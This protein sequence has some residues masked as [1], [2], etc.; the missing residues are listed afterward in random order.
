MKH[1]LVSGVVLG[2]VHAAIVLSLGIQ[3][4]I[5]RERLPR[6]WAQAAA[7]APSSRVHGRYLTLN[8]VPL[9]DAGLAPRVDII[10]KRTIVRPTPIALEARNGRL[11]AHRAVASRVD[12]VRADASE[13]AGAMIAERVDCFLPPNAAD[14]MP[15]LRAG[16]LWVEV[17]VPRQGPPRPLRLGA[18]R[19]GRIEPLSAAR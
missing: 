18:M 13:D 7:A 16:E 12:L 8:L 6:A 5:G 2:V 15:L 17:S 19:N 1:P 11:L 4:A 14:P 3:A 9:A 10:D